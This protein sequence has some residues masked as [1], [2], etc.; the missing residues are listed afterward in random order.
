MWIYVILINIELVAKILKFLK[1]SF[2]LSHLLINSSNETLG[3]FDWN[4]AKPPPR[5][6]RKE[7]PL[8]CYFVFFF[9]GFIDKKRHNLS[10]NNNT[11]R[12]PS[13]YSTNSSRSWYIKPI[14][15]TWHK[16]E[17]QK[18]SVDTRVLILT[19]WLLFFC[20]ILS[21]TENHKKVIA[22]HWRIKKECFDFFAF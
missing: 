13:L 17:E 3:Y 20:C 15:A 9:S 1:F 11:T 7:K 12:S 5:S 6:W 19:R 4:T 10:I 21:N 18:E 16:T 22:M 2:H 14:H 8:F